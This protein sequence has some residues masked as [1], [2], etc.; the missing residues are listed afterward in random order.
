MN[1]TFSKAHVWKGRIENE[2]HDAPMKFFRP[3]CF[4]LR[5]PLYILKSVIN[6][7]KAPYCSLALRKIPCYFVS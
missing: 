4:N 5:N 1:R 6:F 7:L 3:A 2:A